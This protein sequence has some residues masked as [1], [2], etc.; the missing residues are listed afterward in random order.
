MART[1][2]L[3]NLF[4][5][6]EH[7]SILTGWEFPLMSLRIVKETAAFAANRLA[8]ATANASEALE[9]ITQAIAVGGALI[10]FGRVGLHFL[11]GV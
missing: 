4:G 9:A 1:F 6:S 7:S 2:A 5:W 10:I 3:D 11:A 8:C